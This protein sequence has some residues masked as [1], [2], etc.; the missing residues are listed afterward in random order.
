MEAHLMRK[1]MLSI[2]VLGA[3]VFTASAFAQAHL[4]GAAQLGGGAH[5]GAS[6]PAA[7]H[8]VDQTAMQ[9]QR[10]LQRT[11][12]R[13]KHHSRKIRSTVNDHANANANA[14]ASG[15]IGVG[16]GDSHAHANVDAGAGLDTAASAGKA[17]AMGQGVGGEVRDAAHTAIQSTDRAAGSVGDAVQGVN[18]SG[19]AQVSGNASSRGH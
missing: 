2:L 16:A 14:H 19:N 10:S 7:T 6:A 3:S 11:D 9:A 13:L 17:G 5:V 18:A 15:A 8:A 4:G 12:S 1:T